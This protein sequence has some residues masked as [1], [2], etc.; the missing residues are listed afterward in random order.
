MARDQEFETLMFMIDWTVDSCL[1]QGLTEDETAV[2]VRA[3][4][5][6]MMKW[7]GTQ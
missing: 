4:I 5:D 6:E 3:V 7:K 1:R 2:A